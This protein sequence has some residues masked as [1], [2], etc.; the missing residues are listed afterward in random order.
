MRKCIRCQEDMILDLKIFVSNGA[1]G[2]D[3]REGGFFKNSLGKIKGALCPKCG[4]VENY[5]DED[6]L[7]K[8]NAVKKV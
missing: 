6:N 3:I 8:I 5:I 2:I 7:K 1:Y 4:Y